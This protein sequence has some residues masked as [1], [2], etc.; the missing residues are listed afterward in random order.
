MFIAYQVTITFQ[1]FPLHFTATFANV[2][3]KMLTF[4]ATKGTRVLFG[5]GLYFLKYILYQINKVL[6]DKNPL[7]EAGKELTCS[8][9]RLL[10]SLSSRALL[11]QT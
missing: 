8:E 11:N 5:I 9:Y 2:T 10:F 7:D 6:S 3:E 1:I 4:Y